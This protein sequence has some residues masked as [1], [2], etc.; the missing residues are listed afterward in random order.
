MN[1]DALIG[2]LGGK[3]GLAAAFV[4]NV[5]GLWSGQAIFIHEQ[6]GVQVTI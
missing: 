5:N 3:A 6:Y 1:E 4:Q 2:S